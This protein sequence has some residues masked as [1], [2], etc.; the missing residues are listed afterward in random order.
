LPP[1]TCGEEAVDGALALPGALSREG[2]LSLEGALSRL[3][4]LAED[5]SLSDDG[6]LAPVGALPLGAE[7]CCANADPRH[8]TKIKIE[9][10]ATVRT[11]E[12]FIMEIS[13]LTFT[14]ATRDFPETGIGGAKAMLPSFASASVRG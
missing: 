6:A 1:E 5:G 2:S 3:G 13:T 7:V 12:R 11:R 9:R 14:L 8:P 10:D 4:L